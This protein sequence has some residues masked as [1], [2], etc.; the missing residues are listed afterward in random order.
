MTR[1]KYPRC[2]YYH[3]MMDLR[4]L[5]FPSFRCSVFIIN[6]FNFRNCINTI[7]AFKFRIEKANIGLGINLAVTNVWNCRLDVRG[8]S[9]DFRRGGIP[10]AK[11]NFLRRSPSAW[12][13]SSVAVACHAVLRCASWSE[14]SWLRSTN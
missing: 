10:T 2:Q 11:T 5:L 6:M 7:N 13:Y 8:W 1:R 12:C 4:L 3:C 9:L 14:N